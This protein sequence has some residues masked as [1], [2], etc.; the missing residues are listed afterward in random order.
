MNYASHTHIMRHHAISD[1]LHIIRLALPEYNSFTYLLC[2]N[3]TSTSVTNYLFLKTF[4]TGVLTLKNFK[5]FFNSAIQIFFFNLK[6]WFRCG[7]TTTSCDY[8]FLTKHYI[9]RY[10]VYKWMAGEN[11]KDFGTRDLANHLSLY[12]RIEEHVT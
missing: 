7:N 3:F 9:S 8:I 12:G 11:S 5:S 1:N 6:Y 4:F 2:F 10:S